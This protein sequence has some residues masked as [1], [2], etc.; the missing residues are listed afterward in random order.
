MLLF[1]SENVRIYIE[2]GYIKKQSFHAPNRYILGI[3]CYVNSPDVF[4]ANDIRNRGTIKIVQPFQNLM[5]IRE[6][7]MTASLKDEFI[8]PSIYFN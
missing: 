2:Y 4:N 3:I 7:A 6:F 5:R 1:L 8:H